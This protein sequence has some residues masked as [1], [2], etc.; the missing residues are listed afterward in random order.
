MSIAA[1]ATPICPVTGK[2]AIRRV[3]WVTSKLLADLWRIT[4]GVD[5]RGSFSDAERFGLWESPTGLY[6]FDPMLV[7]DQAFYTQLYAR[8]MKR[9]LWSHDADRHAF[10]LAAKR[11]APGDRVLDVGCGFASFRTVIPHADYVGLD[12]NFGGV[13]DVRRETLGQHLGEHSGTYDV[14]CA[15]EVLEHLASPAQMF[16]D[17]VRAA[18]PGGLVI[19]SVPHVPSAM[20]RIP[21]FVFNAPPH[22]LTWWTEGALRAL[23][24][25]NGAGVENIERA[26]WSGADALI[27]WIGRCT[28]V[29]CCD[30]HYRGTFAWHAA[31]LAGFLAGRLVYAVDKSP[32]TVDEGAGLVMVARRN[33]GGSAT[34]KSA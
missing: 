11:I 9:K 32:K 3:Q 14:V 17:M 18:R 26:Q 6:F 8:L 23:A 19:V 21:N 7:G 22:H 25:A 2:P 15:F 4:F 10:A 20:T 28:P 1:E 34:R 27:Y 29:R 24:E 12:P 13:G 30:T 16:A 31:T 5:V 33:A